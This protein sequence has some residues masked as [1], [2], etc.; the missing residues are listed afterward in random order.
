M[1][2]QSGPEVALTFE[3]QF[4]E[5]LAWMGRLSDAIAKE[6]K[7]LIAVGCEQ[8][9]KGFI[10][11]SRGARYCSLRCRKRHHYR[12]KDRRV[13]KNGA[14]DGSITLEKLF[15]RDGGK[16]RN[17]GL[18]M[19]FDCDPN[20]DSYPSIDHIVPLAKGGLHSW[21]NVQLLCR[22]CNSD[23]RDMLIPFRP[24][25]E[26]AWFRAR[27]ATKT[28]IYPPGRDDSG[29]LGDCRGGPLSHRAEKTEKSPGIRI[30]PESP[31]ASRDC[32]AQ[33]RI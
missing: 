1:R 25:L 28:F 22:G 33:E 3:E 21:D 2:R 27:R 4:G 7:T 12:L 9:G 23:K 24:A 8:C 6:E 13:W 18:P 14:P 16:C 10:T 26:A 32:G 17:C 31:P 11:V 30:R 15:V 19:T 20:G 5:A 29:P